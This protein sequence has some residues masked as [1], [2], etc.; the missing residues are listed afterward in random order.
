MLGGGG[1]GPS[2]AMSMSSL[3]TFLPLACGC[4]LFAGVGLV[5]PRSAADVAAGALRG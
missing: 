2:R 5:A 4:D 3:S 1:A